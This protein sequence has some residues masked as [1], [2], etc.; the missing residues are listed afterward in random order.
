MSQTLIAKISL[1]VKGHASRTSMERFFLWCASFFREPR[2]Q[3]E[4]VELIVQIDDQYL[5]FLVWRE[6]G[7][8]VVKVNGTDVCTTSV[9]PVPAVSVRS[10]A[11]PIL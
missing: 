9:T 3:I 5:K 6:G 7:I 10:K 1:A 8:A 11:L 2:K 4:A